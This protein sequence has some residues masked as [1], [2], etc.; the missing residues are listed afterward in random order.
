MSATPTFAF[1]IAATWFV[2][3]AR[4]LYRSASALAEAAFAFSKPAVALHTAASACLDF[5]FED[6]GIEERDQ[7]ACFDTSVKVG[8]KGLDIPG[9]LASDLHIYHCVCKLLWQR[10][11]SRFGPVQGERI[12]I[13]PSLSETHR[14]RQDRSKNGE[15]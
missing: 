9:D 8:I 1:A 15:S 7:L 5:G 12:G 6:V 3:A 11:T 4:E 14:P 10:R 13:Q 2:S